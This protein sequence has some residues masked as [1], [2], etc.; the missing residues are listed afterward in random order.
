M[1]LGR[2]K[3]L[4]LR[5]AN[6][7]RR[8]NLPLRGRTDI[9]HINLDTSVSRCLNFFRLPCVGPYLIYICRRVQLDVAVTYVFFLSNRLDVERIQK[10]TK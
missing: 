8:I 10:K 2:I 7:I 6:A 3:F 9:S 4:V 5:T 1:V